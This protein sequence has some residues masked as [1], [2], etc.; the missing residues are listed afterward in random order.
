MTRRANFEVYAITNGVRDLYIGQTAD[1]T[2]RLKKHNEGTGSA[3]TRRYGGPWRVLY[4]VTAATRAEAR[5]IER[6]WTARLNSGLSM[7]F[8][9]FKPHAWGPRDH[10]DN[11]PQEWH[12]NK[13]LAALTIEHQTTLATMNRTLAEQAPDTTSA[14]F[15]QAERKAAHRL[16]KLG[17]TAKR[18]NKAGAPPISIKR[19]DRDPT[20]LEKS[21]R[22]MQHALQIALD[23]IA[24]YAPEISA[25]DH[26]ATQRQQTL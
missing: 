20:M 17:F 24:R 19:E 3:F 14:A 26:H 15:K 21:A 12:P 16:A 7:P 1:L 22:T 23:H 2:A 13:S 5:C 9:T 6:W 10:H 4:T 8:L 18:S 11:N 25:E